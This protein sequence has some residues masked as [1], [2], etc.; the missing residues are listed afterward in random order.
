MTA[1]KARTIWAAIGIFLIPAGIARAG[2]SP[3][4]PEAAAPAGWT[5]DSSL[6]PSGEPNA[7]D[8]PA[9][10]CA[11]RPDRLSLSECQSGLA[12][13]RADS[14]FNPYATALRDEAAE[15]S[16]VQQLPASPGGASLLLSGLLSIGAFH[17]ARSA[18]HLHLAALPAWYHE[19][20]P[21][22]IGHTVAF[23]FDLADMPVCFV[24]EIGATDVTDNVLS[25]HEY[26]RGPPSRIRSQFV[27]PVIAPRGPPIIF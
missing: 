8:L 7:S 20:C 16:G 26:L 18:R 9:N 3:G 22:R 1:L 24:A 2:L 27:L 13:L 25:V 23:D 15:P 11:L 12:G 19:A 17:L 14:L 5:P 10:P 4:L 21:E 6:E